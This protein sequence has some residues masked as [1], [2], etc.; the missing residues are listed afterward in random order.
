MFCFNQLQKRAP[1]SVERA[2]LEVF[3]KKQAERDNTA[4][5][6]Y[7]ENFFI[8]HLPVFLEV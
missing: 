8:R 4:N 7:E 1:V 2:I 5:Y 6:L 3:V